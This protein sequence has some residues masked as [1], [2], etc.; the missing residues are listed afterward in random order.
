MEIAMSSNSGHGISVG[1]F[2][3]I[4]D[5]NASLNRPSQLI[6]DNSPY[7]LSVD[8]NG[9]PPHNTFVLSNTPHSAMTFPRF[10]IPFPRLPVRHYIC[11]RPW[12]G[13]NSSRFFSFN[14]TRK[15]L[16]KRTN[17]ASC[18]RRRRFLWKELKCSAENWNRKR[19]MKLGMS[20]FSAYESWWDRT[21]PKGRFS[22]W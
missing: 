7:S 5:V 12:W 9:S 15:T 21:D 10:C 4:C 13:N 17:R 19:R 16:L 8:L 22:N 6:K 2:F 1:L 11:H 3:I 18:G 20:K 14:W